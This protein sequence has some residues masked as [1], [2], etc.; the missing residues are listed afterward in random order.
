M[1]CHTKTRTESD[2]YEGGERKWGYTS[3]RIKWDIVANASR[4]HTVTYGV[5]GVKGEPSSVNNSVPVARAHLGTV[6]FQGA[7]LPSMP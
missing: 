7:M 2:N 3:A 4:V 6:P 1:A 5:L